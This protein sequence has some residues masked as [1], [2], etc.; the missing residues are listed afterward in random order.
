MSETFFHLTAVSDNEKTGPIPVSTTSRNTCPPA[1]PFKKN[2]CYAEQAP[3]V[4][5]WNKVSKGE[6]GGSLEAFT[7]AI[8]ALPKGQLWRHNQAGELPG[9]ENTID[10]EAFRA[11]IAANKGRKGYT[12]T[13][14]PMDEANKALIKE[15]NAA[16]FTVN[17]SGNN[18]KH[19]DELK[20]LGVAPVTAIV[21]ENA[22]DKGETPAGNRWVACPAQ[23]REGVT[24]ASC[25]LCSVASRGIIVA[26]KAH[27]NGKK[28]AMA[29][30]ASF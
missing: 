23:T 30:S 17:L 11:I 19:A 6:R 8:K 18:L 5:H 20:A 4:F 1:C 24:C 27:G 9:E 10:A 16:G 12:Y 13:H 22:P 29:A 3:L 28:K 2:G 15:A 26:F 7:Q 25:K 14:K 21:P